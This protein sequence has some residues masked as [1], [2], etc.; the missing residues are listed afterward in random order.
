MPAGRPDDPKENRCLLSP[1]QLPPNRPADHDPYDPER[2]PRRTLAGPRL[3]DYS[4]P[5]PPPDPGPAV[6]RPHQPQKRIK[7]EAVVP[8]EDNPLRGWRGMGASFLSKHLWPRDA[9]T[10][11][12]MVYYSGRRRGRFLEDALGLFPWMMM[13]AFDLVLILFSGTTTLGMASTIGLMEFFGLFTAGSIF[14]AAMTS[15]HLRRT[16]GNLPLDELLMTR[17]K[18]LDVV[19]GLSIRPISVQ[20][21]GVILYGLGHAAIFTYATMENNWS[22][23]PAMLY[24]CIFTPF[25]IHLT[26]IGTEWGGAIATRA[27]LCLRS[28]MVASLRMLF[29]LLLGFIGLGIVLIFMLAVGFVLYCLFSCLFFGLPL[30]AIATPIYAMLCAEVIKS[31]ASDAMDWCHHYPDEWWIANDPGGGKTEHQERTLFTPWKPIAGRRKIFVR[32]T[33]RRSEPPPEVM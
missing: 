30:L 22:I 10:N 11:P 18:P 3:V 25:R 19:Q 17:L 15:F 20:S 2:L 23:W 12:V 32:R 9:R 28:T 6:P 21:A 16:M 13:I 1:D 27:Q 24:L 8:P 4:K 26:R 7:P 5:A 31:M 29:D 14:S 33:L